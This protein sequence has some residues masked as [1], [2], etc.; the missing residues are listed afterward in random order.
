MCQE[1]QKIYC[2]HCKERLGPLSFIVE[3][4]ITLPMPSELV[5]QKYIIYFHKK[6]FDQMDMWLQGKL[7]NVPR[8][9]MEE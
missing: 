5:E 1:Q 8:E 6:C 7:D 9:T 2:N 3:M 4:E